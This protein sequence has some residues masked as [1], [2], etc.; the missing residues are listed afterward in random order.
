MEAFDITGQVTLGLYALFADVT[1]ER[2]A[3]AGRRSRV[4]RDNYAVAPGPS[5]ASA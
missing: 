2:A 1:V 5:D 3:D 4:Q